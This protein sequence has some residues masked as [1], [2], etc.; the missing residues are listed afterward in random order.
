MH[1]VMVGHG[2]QGFRGVDP[3]AAGVPPVP[4][5]P[6]LLPPPLLPDGV[7]PVPPVPPLELPLAEAPAEPLWPPSFEAASP[8]Q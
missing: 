7:P 4:A 1:T 2:S 5:P 6:K 3:P 8:P